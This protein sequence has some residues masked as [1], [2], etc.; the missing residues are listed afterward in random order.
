MPA[1]RSQPDPVNYSQ[2][3]KFFWAPIATIIGAVTLIV[4]FI[5]L[6]RGDFTTVTYVVLVLVTVL[7]VSSLAW[8]GFSRKFEDAKRPSRPYKPPLRYPNTYKWARFGLVL[9]VLAGIT[10]QYLLYLRKVEM[11]GKVVVLVARMDGPEEQFGITNQLLEQLNRS[12]QGND[13]IL[14]IPLRQTITTDMS[15]GEIR[16]IGKKYAASILIWGWY[17]STENPNLTLHVENLAPKVISVLG[18]SSIMKPAG[19]ISELNSFSLQEKVGEEITALVLFLDGYMQYNAENYDDALHQFSAALSSKNWS[20]ELVNKAHAYLYRGNIYL[21]QNQYAQALADYD[22]VV[23]LDPQI[24]DV[25]WNRAIAAFYVQDYQKSLDDFTKITELDPSSKE[26]FFNVGVSHENLGNYEGGIAGYSNAIQIDPQ[27]KEAY[28]YRGLA[29]S[30]HGEYKLAIKDFSTAA[31]IDAAYLDAYLNRGIAYLYSG[32]NEKAIADLHQVLEIDPKKK[33]G[34]FYLGTVYYWEN[35]FQN[36]IVNFTSAVQIDPEYLDAYRSRSLAFYFAGDYENAMK[37]L[38]RLIRSN[39]SDTSIF[40]DRGVLYKAL[41]KLEEAI[42]D[43]Q[44]CIEF[45]TDPAI[46]SDAEEQLKNLSTP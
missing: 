6:W 39:Y 36:A 7:V 38:N 46:K 13:D 22:M 21:S 9:L 2:I 23:Q 1:K 44:Q 37:D 26:A 16:K 33:E 20:S 11:L 3:L 5:Q 45:A 25:Y 28:L 29:Y 24:N 30:N 34:Y 12:I 18:P 42:R 15:N 31:Q 35:D 14:I 43:Y 32:D 19:T 41:N 8:V 4:N 40:C 17:R 10:G 27:Y